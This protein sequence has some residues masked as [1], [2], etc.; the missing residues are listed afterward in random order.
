A[1]RPRAAPRAGAPR[2]PD[3]L[4]RRS[5]RGNVAFALA[6]RGG[7]DWA[8]VDAALVE[9]DLGHA[10]HLPAARLSGGERQRM[11]M[12]RALVTR[13]KLLL[14]DEPSASLDPNA[15]LLLE[16]MIRSASARG[17]GVILSTH[18][19]AQARRLGG[20]V[21]FLDRGQVCERG[22]TRDFLAAPESPEGAA[23]LEGHF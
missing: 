13:P 10:A 18:N 22:K 19:I 16:G 17:I 9:A 3:P 8:L 11:A 21:V 1:P 20:D 6:A 12:A 5:V 4:L 7:V 23:Y 2:G 15:T 14:L